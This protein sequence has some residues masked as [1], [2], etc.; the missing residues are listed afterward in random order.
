MKK[1]GK[2]ALPKEDRLNLITLCI[3]V[4][5]IFFAIWTFTGT[6]PLAG[7]PYN[8]Y[9]LQAQAWLDGRLDLGQNYSHLEIAI[10]EGKYFISFPPFPS[11]VMLPFVL[12]GFDKCDGLIALISA[13]MGVVYAYKIFDHYGNGGNRGMLFALLLTIGSN[14]LFTGQIAWVW[15]IAQNMAFTLSLMAIYYALKGKGGLSLLFWACAVG[16]RPMQAFYLPVLLYLLYNNYKEQGM[17]NLWSKIKSKW[18]CVIPMAVIALSYMILN[19]AR[20]GNPTEFGHNYLPEHTQSQYG[21]FHYVYI[22]DNLK[23]LFRLPTISYKEPWE[24]QRFNGTNIFI[25]SPIFISYTVYTIYALI[26]KKGD[27]KLILLSLGMIALEIIALTAHVTMGGSQFGHRYI[28][29][30]LPL[31]YLTL[32]TAMPEDSRY[33]KLNI[34]LLLFG[35]AVNIGGS[36]LYYLR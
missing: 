30:V 24:Y 25:I 26:K 4:F 34:I 29:D 9:I 11:Y 19:F 28:N 32:A 5:G 18:K 2:I 20:F 31:V 35:M 36:I 16:C 12:V 8:S 6:W 14:W 33:D 1:Q 15:F 13:L 27:R 23:T 21:Q 3:A 7:Q 17:E 10:F 22:L